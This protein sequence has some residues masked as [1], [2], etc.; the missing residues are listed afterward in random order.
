MT[1]DIDLEKAAKGLKESISRLEEPLLRAVIE[2]RNMGNGGIADQYFNKR[3][4]GFTKIVEKYA[5]QADGKVKELYNS[6]QANLDSFRDE[7]NLA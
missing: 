1:I 7:Y 2:V 3:V 4:E 6:L 5:A